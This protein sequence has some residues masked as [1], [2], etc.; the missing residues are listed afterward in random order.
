MN[1]QNHPT[2]APDAGVAWRKSSRSGGYQNCVE[3][4]PL[5]DGVGLRDSK[6]RGGPSF[7]F[8][9]GAWVTFL[10]DVRL[11]HHDGH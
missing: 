3:V 4:A 6:D 1:R 11:G 9:P 10:D 8:S 7:T 5:V 2:P